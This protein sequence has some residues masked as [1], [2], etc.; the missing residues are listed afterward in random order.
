M[1]LGLGSHLT[2]WVGE[3]RPYQGAGVGQ[4]SGTK[5]LTRRR[6]TVLAGQVG[7]LRH[8]PVP[9]CESEDS[10]RVITFDLGFLGVPFEK[11]KSHAMSHALR[12]A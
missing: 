9:F 11:L 10:A 1:R 3:Q 12:R 6:E 2:L 8:W 5:T 7:M 4:G